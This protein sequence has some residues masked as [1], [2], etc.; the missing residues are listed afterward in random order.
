MHT[1]E[2]GECLVRFLVIV[3]VAEIEGVGL[4]YKSFVA[5]LRS[6]TCKEMQWQLGNILTLNLTLTGDSSSS[7]AQKTINQRGVL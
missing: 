3:V 2:S 7:M 6:S 5:W 4:L 1:M